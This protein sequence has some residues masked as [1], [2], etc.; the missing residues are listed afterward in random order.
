MVPPVYNIILSPFPPAVPRAGTAANKLLKNIFCVVFIVVP[1]NVDKH[2]VTFDNVVVPDT[3]NDDTHVA[4]FANVVLP[5]TFNVLKNVDGLFKLID[6][7]GLN[8]LL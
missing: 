7:G 8:I 5:L 1:D 4:K 6:D 3:F 2:V